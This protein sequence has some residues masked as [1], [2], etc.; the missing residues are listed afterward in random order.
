MPTKMQIERQECQREGD[1]DTGEAS[2][3]KESRRCYSHYSQPVYEKNEPFSI[4]NTP[5]NNN[6][7]LME[8]PRNSLCHKK[9]REETLIRSCPP[10]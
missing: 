1:T 4:P 9:G 7:H 5:L 10:G 6:K 8:A 2:N 3:G